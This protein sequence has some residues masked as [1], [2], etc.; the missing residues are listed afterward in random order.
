MV[1]Y[2]FALRGEPAEPRAEMRLMEEEVNIMKGEQ[3]AEHFLCDI[4]PTGEV[5]ASS[6]R[7]KYWSHT[8]RCLFSLLWMEK[9][10]FQIVWR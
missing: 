5:S 2:T 10:S 9:T 6:N 4:N 1:R 7:A 3:L 8:F